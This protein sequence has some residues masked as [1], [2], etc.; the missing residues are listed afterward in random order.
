MSQELVGKVAIVTGGA[1][2]IGRE[3]VQLFALEGAKV[4]IADLDAQGEELAARLGDAVRFKKT[5]MS[6]PEEVQSLVDYAVAEFGGLHVMYNNAGMSSTMMR[7]LDDDFKDFHRVM[8][9]NVLGTILGTQ[10]AARHMAKHGG[11]SIITTSSTAGVLASFGLTS[12]RA[13]KAAIAQFTKAAAIE[14][15]EHGIRVNCILPGQIETG[16]I[17][18]TLGAHMGQEK[19]AELERKIRDV[20]MSCQ[21]LKRRGAVGDV[22]Q[23]ALYLAS[24][25]SAYVTGMLLPVDAG[26]TAGDSVNHLEQILRVRAEAMRG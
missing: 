16:I 11:G 14:V 1:K 12:Y 13:S 2:G 15:A 4:V 6:S 25:R 10:R 24:D 7:L 8:S 9:V 20:M 23:A 5:D 21:P 17:G 18:A 22:A 26:I 3:A 19:I